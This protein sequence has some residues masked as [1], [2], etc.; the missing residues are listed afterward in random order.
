MVPESISVQDGLMNEYR[1]ILESLLN[2]HH[3]SYALKQDVL[4]CPGQI[5][6]SNGNTISQC[7]REHKTFKSIEIDIPS[8]GNIDVIAKTHFGIK[9]TLYLIEQI[10]NRLPY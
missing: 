4:D 5:L 8:M 9:G 7:C 2:N 6:L 3:L 10:L 1:N